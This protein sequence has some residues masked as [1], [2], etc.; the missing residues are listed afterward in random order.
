MIRFMHREIEKIRKLI[1]SLGAVVEDRVR[2]ATRALE[3]QDSATAQMII[4]TDWEIDEL[5]VEV[6]EECLKILALHQPVAVD[7]RFLVTAIKITNDLE[8]VGDLAVNIAHNVITMGQ[9]SSQNL[10]FDYSRMADKAE[11]MVRMSLDALVHL[12]ADMAQLVVELD[13]DV[14]RIQRDAYDRITALL[15]QSPEQAG[16]FI[17]LLLVSR[18]LERLADH[19]TNIAE[20]I[21]YLIDGAIVRHQHAC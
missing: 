12:D 3:E 1:L 11:N 20:E 14:D 19:A 8:R 6:E 15:Q 16:Y 2:M 18:H 5:E 7:L 13:D 17:N 9:Y 21:I 10:V 4:E